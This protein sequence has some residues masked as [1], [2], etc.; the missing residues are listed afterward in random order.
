[1][2]KHP[3][4]QSSVLREEKKKRKEEKQTLLPESAQ[5]K[6]NTVQA[7]TLRSQ[8]TVDLFISFIKK[9]KWDIRE[10]KQSRNF[11]VNRQ[12]YLFQFFHLLTGRPQTNI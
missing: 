11:E 10:N 7:E 2:I 5:K 8:T 12:R 1:M 9:T 3:W 4:A 6:R